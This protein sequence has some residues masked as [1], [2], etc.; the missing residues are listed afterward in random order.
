MNARLFT[1]LGLAV[2]TAGTA[3]VA[4]QPKPVEIVG[5]PTVE[6]V[7]LPP[8]EL[9]AVP[10]IQVEGLPPVAIASMPPV[11][12]A[13]LPAVE[14]AESSFDC[15]VST[16]LAEASLAVEG[17]FSGQVDLTFDEPTIVDNLYFNFQV[18][19]GLHC[20]FML[21]VHDQYGNAVPIF[22]DWGFSELVELLP[23]QAFVDTRGD[24]FR[25]FPLNLLFRGPYEWLTL[26][27]E[28]YE[29]PGVDPED[30]CSAALT[31]TT[32]PAG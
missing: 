4:D 29:V 25:I 16:G 14:L 19:R 26:R 5:T 1:A 8:I 17:E 11:D 27:I 2:L 23:G 3:A 32:R 31:A 22:S 7:A 12:I 15:N 20:K 24:D 10:P 18:D 6:V 30:G 9:M 21:W 28:R 13:S